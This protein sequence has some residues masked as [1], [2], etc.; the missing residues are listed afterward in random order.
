MG[1][2]VFYPALEYTFIRESPQMT[3]L[4]LFADIGG[5]LGL[6]ISASIFT[7]FEIIE[8]LVLVLKVLFFRE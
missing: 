7:L 3:E 4:G 6:F 5:T 1:L 8:I 2:I